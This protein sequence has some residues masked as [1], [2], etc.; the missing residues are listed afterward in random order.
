MGRDRLEYWDRNAPIVCETDRTI[1]WQQAREMVLSAYGRF[2][3]DMAGIASAFFDKNWIDRLCAMA[4][5]RRLRA[6]R[7]PARIPTS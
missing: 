6:R 2:S 3:P 1:S 4:N 5:R 7:C